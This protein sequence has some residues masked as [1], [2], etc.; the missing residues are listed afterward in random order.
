ML[1]WLNA[2]TKHTAGTDQA[3]SYAVS[4]AP[5]LCSPDLIASQGYL[6]PTIFSYTIHG[7]KFDNK[8]NYIQHSAMSSL[9]KQ[10]CSIPIVENT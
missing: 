10:I 8:D 6:E 5:V 1:A 3:S 2:Q 9:K 4:S 7:T